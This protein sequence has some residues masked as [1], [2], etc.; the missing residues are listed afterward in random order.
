[1]MRC[2]HDEVICQHS[3]HRINVQDCGFVYVLAGQSWLTNTH[4]YLGD[5]LA[6]TDI[7][8]CTLNVLSGVQS[9]AMLLCIYIYCLSWL[10]IMGCGVGTQN[11]RL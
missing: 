5:H 6:L 9:S 2:V 8:S 7:V 1:M 11:T 10:P 4:L 3:H